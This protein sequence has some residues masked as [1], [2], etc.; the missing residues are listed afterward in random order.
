VGVDVFFVVS[1]FLITGLLVGELR[2]HGRISL[3]AFYARR[4][5]RLLPASVLVLVASVVLMQVI[6]PP[7]ALLEL[8][9]DAVSAAL[10]ASNLRFAHQSVR[11]LVDRSPSPLLHYWSLAVEEQFYL[12]WP[13]FVLLVAKVRRGSLARRLGVGVGLLG[14]SSLVA[15]LV[16]TRTN[17]TYAFF[18][19]PARAWELAAGAA[20]ALAAGALPAARTRTGRVLVAGGV[21]AIAIAAATFDQHTL[22]PGVAA[23]LPVAGT[24]AVLAGGSIAGPGRV[25]SSSVLQWLGRRSYAIYLWHWPLLVVPVAGGGSLSWADRAGLVALSIVL[26]EVTMRLI[27]DPVRRARHLV[28][29]P[30]RTFFLGG[31]LTAVALVVAV[32]GTVVPVL[33]AGRPASAAV[34]PYPDF[35]PSDLSPSLLRSNRDLPAIYADQCDT[36]ATR[37]DPVV[38]VYGDPAGPPV[39]LFGDSHAGHWFPAFDIAARADGWRLIPLTKSA[40]PAFDVP[41][42]VP[43]LPRRYVQCDR[44][45][46]RS[47]DVIAHERDPI[48][49]VSGSRLLRTLSGR[50]MADELG[51]GMARMVE[52]LPAG[53]RVVYLADTP[54]PGSIVPICLSEHLHD[55]RRCG[56]PR[57]AA[58]DDGYRTA[59]REAAARVHATFVDLTD[60]ICPVDPCPPI[61]GRLLV[62]RE[63]SHITAQFAA[64]LAERIR[65]AIESIR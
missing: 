52:R 8:R 61:I 6:A 7:L 29:S 36:P 3:R 53:A 12:G 18:L 5:R 44:W 64:S 47:L 65:A 24:V 42:L 13:L 25:L 48:V 55:A 23:V 51:D 40:C 20:L 22:F 41:V 17:E 16:L 27:E 54:R 62:W 1:G 46:E 2:D 50:P 31:A 14:A 33:D 19:L 43:E 45:R 37:I 38:C 30:S 35:V 59:E 9:T 63:S 60:D 39:F 57:D 28:A 11:Y 26:A 56:R 4:M 15:S 58:I 21:V 10:Y 49:V 32:V 34:T